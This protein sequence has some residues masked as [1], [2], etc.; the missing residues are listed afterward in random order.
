MDLPA[1]HG[2]RMANRGNHPI[3]KIVD[4]KLMW[5][6]PHAFWLTYGVYNSSALVAVKS[7]EKFGS[8]LNL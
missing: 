5:V 8:M 4:V 3:R 6:G 7:D 1:S 2:Y